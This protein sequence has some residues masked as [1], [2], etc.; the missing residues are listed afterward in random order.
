MLFRSHRDIKP[1]NILIGQ[2]GEGKLSDFGLALPISVNP[3]KL[4]IKDYKYVLHLAPEVAGGAPYSVVA[5][6][7]S[8]GVTMYRLINGDSFSSMPS[9]SDI[10]DLASAGKFPDRTRY[11]EFVPRAW[12]TLINKTMSVEPNARFRTAEELRHAIESMQIG[13]AHV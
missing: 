10:F 13:R 9:G 11:R 5:D 12:R 2:T 4:G 6:I 8:C 7:Y 3:A 1:A